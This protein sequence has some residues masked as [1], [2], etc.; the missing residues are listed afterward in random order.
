M[1]KLILILLM[2]FCLPGAAAAKEMR[3]APDFSWTD[4]AG[5]THALS[6][7]NGKKVVL[8]FWASWCAPCVAE[9]PALLKAARRAGA[10]TVFLAISADRDKAAA[11]RFLHTIETQAGG[12]PGNVL[13]G[14]DPKQAVSADIFQ[15]YEFPE[16]I[17]LNENHEMEGKTAGPADWRK[18][19]P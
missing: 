3:A 19:V 11:Q 10:G 15:T 4:F 5:R 6:D 2:A 7:L 13:Y 17:F 14:F 8:H 12:R 18:K 1:R 9:F 16:T